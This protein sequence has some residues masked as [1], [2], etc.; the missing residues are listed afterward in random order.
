MENSPR[1]QTKVIPAVCKA[2]PPTGPGSV[3]WLSNPHQAARSPQRVRI[4]MDSR[5]AHGHHRRPA[6]LFSFSLPGV[7]TFPPSLTWVVH[8]TR[9]VSTAFFPPAGSPPPQLGGG[10]SKPPSPSDL[11]RGTPW[12]TRNQIFFSGAKHWRIW[13]EKMCWP[14]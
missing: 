5:L 12:G 11:E 3:F 1:P 6:L 9:V 7:P 10:G 4:G 13:P 8:H 2:P 14:F